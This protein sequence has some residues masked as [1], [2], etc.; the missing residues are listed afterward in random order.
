METHRKSNL[1]AAAQTILIIVFAAVFFFAPGPRL[2]APLI[3]GYVIS[4][5]GLLIIAAGFA[6]L[7]GVVQIQPEPR[8]DGHL[9]TSGVYRWLRH[10]MYTGIVL[11][12]AGLFLRV[13]AVFVAIAGV[14]II[15]FLFVKSRF[16]EQLLSAR[17]VDYAAYRKRAWW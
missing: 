8:A 13:P 4:L 10:P 2:F 3:A 11:V 17:Y 1:Y 16:E 5:A 12:I 14:V 9:V 15:V 6:S 7:R